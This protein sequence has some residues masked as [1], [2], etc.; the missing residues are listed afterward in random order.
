MELSDLIDTLAQ[1]APSEVCDDAA[2]DPKWSDPSRLALYKTVIYAG[3]TFKQGSRVLA[4][5]PPGMSC[6]PHS[7]HSGKGTPIS[8]TKIFGKV[9]LLSLCI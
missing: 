5:L 1:H 8:H 7:N 6:Q 4:D 2:D 3:N 9:S